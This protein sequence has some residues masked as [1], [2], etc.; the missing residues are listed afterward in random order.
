M[1][2]YEYRCQNC[3]K[4]VSIYQSYED[5]GEV[6][7]Q[8]PECGSRALKRL[9]NR[10]RIARSEDSRIED[11]AD[12]SAWGDFD[13]QDPRSMARM[14]RKMG[15]EMGEEMPPELD[16]VVDRLEAGESPEEIEKNMPD[17]GEGMEGLG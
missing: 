11:M 12:P 2:F 14:I 1:P 7:V 6:E 9:I 4:R 16:E 10:V 17:F 8:C 5:Y 3:K 15:Q 13:E